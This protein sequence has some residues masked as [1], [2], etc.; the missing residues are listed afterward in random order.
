MHLGEG[1]K[2][3]RGQTGRVEIGANAGELAFSLPSRS[4]PDPSGG[5][6]F[7]P[8]EKIVGFFDGSAPG[9]SAILVNFPDL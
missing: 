3:P 9:F 1:E 2:R 6:I 8:G 4:M 7:P 5:I